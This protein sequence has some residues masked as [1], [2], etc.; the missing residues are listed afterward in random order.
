MKIK[1]ANYKCFGDEP[2]GFDNIKKI[3]LII[4]KNNSGKSTLCDLFELLSADNWKDYSLDRDFR[5]EYS[6][7]ISDHSFVSNPVWSLLV[8]NQNVE[9]YLKL[10]YGKEVSLYINNKRETEFL[11]VDSENEDIRNFLKANFSF[12]KRPF[13]KYKVVKIKAERDIKS[14]GGLNAESG[15]S[16]SGDG[17]S[18]LLGGLLTNHNKRSPLVVRKFL[19]EFNRILN[20]EINFMGMK[21]VFYKDNWEISFSTDNLSWNTVSEMGTG[22]KTIIHLLVDLVVLPELNKIKLDNSIFIFEELENNLHPLIQRKLF[23]FIKEIAEKHNSYY[24]ITTHSN[25]PVDL[26]WNSEIA[27]IVRVTKEAGK[28]TVT[29]VI[30]HLDHH[31]LLNEL[32]FKA[33]DLLQTNGII[34]VE[35]P[36]DRTYL[37]RWLSIVN[38]DLREGV[39][40]TIMFYGGRLLAGISFS[41]FVTE[42]LVPMLKINRNAHVVMDSDILVNSSNRKTINATKERILTELGKDK[43]WIT[44]GKEIEN[45]LSKRLLFSW[46]QKEEQTKSIDNIINCKFDEFLASLTSINYSSKKSK[47]SMEIAELISNSDLDIGDLRAKLQELVDRINSW[48][49]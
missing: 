25:I 41:E 24:F 21:P 44:E 35:G 33:S 2:Q 14:T 45:Y 19:Q 29:N 42:N 8:E 46:L 26:F 34:W 18:T 12:L 43:C 37:L 48:N 40:F 15:I 30:S 20:P 9:N 1:I 7:V 49:N 23:E 27:Q 39:H 11:N 22:I 16:N 38:P 5:I 4:G 10:M 28:S 36:S 32:G 6:S 17:I 3:N 31:N 47:Y 13:G